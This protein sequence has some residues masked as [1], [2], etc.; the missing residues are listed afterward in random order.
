MV[1]GERHL[2]GADQVPVVLGEVVDVLGRL[3]EE[4]GAVHGRRADQ[5][6]GDHRDEAGRGGLGDRH[7]DQGE[8]QQ[9]A[10]TG[11]VVGP[12]A[13]HLGTALG[14]DRP[15]DLAQLD[16]VAGL[17]ALGR[18]VARGAD[19]LQ[20]DEVLLAADRGG[21]VDEVGQRAEQPVGLLL[22]LGL[23]G[24]GG[25]D[26]GG[27]VLGALQ[28]GGLLLALGLGDLL[29]EALLL[30]AQFVEPTARGP[31]ALVGCEECVDQV[32]VLATGALRGAHSVR[33]LT[34]QAKVNHGPSLPVQPPPVDNL[35]ITGPPRSLE[36]SCPQAVPEPCG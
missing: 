16:V 21:R 36:A 1:R 26:L 35:W 10:D 19:L 30:I 15:E 13:G 29:A 24:V 25:L 27:Q 14:V 32:D 20:R 3:A 17:E 11:Q 12:G 2:A 23:L 8:L 28:Q 7:V 33:V 31:A 9:R 6:R 22:G 18:E 34:K 5:G 4:A